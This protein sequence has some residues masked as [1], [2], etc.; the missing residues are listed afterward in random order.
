MFHICLLFLN[1]VVFHVSISV[2]IRMEGRINNHEDSLLVFVL[3]AAFARSLLRASKHTQVKQLEHAPLIQLHGLP[4]LSSISLY[5]IEWN[6]LRLLSLFS[7]IVL[8][9]RNIYDLWKH[10]FGDQPCNCKT[11]YPSLWQKFGFGVSTELLRHFVCHQNM[12]AHY[13]GIWEAPTGAL[14]VAWI[15][16]TTQIFNPFMS[17]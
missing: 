3:L 9:Q 5:V 4:P 1:T 13:I 8:R 6:F 12:F 2:N 16:Y 17:L 10:I 15:L 11:A 7:W 14:T